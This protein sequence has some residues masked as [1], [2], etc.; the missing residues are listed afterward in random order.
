MGMLLLGLVLG[1][2]SDDLLEGEQR[3][4]DV[5]SLCRPRLVGRGFLGP[6]EID[7]ALQRQR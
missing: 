3:G 2:R 7:Q 5:L 4:V 1:D 6:S